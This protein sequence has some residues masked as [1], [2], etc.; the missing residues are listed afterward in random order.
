MAQNTVKWP[1]IGVNDELWAINLPVDS[2][3]R[4]HLPKNDQPSTHRN[5]SN[6]HYTMWAGYADWHVYIQP[7]EKPHRAKLTKKRP[8]LGEPI[9]SLVVRL[10][11]GKQVCF[12]RGLATKSLKKCM[13]NKAKMP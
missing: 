9:N 3:D 13:K 10:Y 8:H 5:A 2:S 7:I 6:G 12:V 4:T 11:C 1:Y